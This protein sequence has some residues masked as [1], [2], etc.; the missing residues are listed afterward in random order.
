MEDD[1]PAITLCIRGTQAEFQG[2]MEEARWLYTQAWEL[3]GDAYDAC[4]AAHYVAR[5]QT[6]ASEILRW[7]LIA[8]E[9]AN[10]VGDERVAPFYPSLYLNLGK[11]YEILGEADKART[12]Y[13]LAA[14]LGLPHQM[15]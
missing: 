10:A 13:D 1:S 12:Y 3:A 9:K 4:V 6:D 7:N 5:M 8:L 15:D 11:S 2:K 14:E